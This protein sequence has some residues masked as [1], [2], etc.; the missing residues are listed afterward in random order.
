MSQTLSMP[1]APAGGRPSR[2]AQTDSLI[3]E[4]MRSPDAEIILLRHEVAVLRRQVARPKPDW[5]D[6]AVLAA[7]AGWMPAE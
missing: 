2:N 6:Q 7:L 5:A 4:C 3:T 1:A